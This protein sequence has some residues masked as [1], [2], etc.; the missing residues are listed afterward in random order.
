MADE[1]TE[2]A[3]GST[4]PA[5]ETKGANGPAGPAPKKAKEP[6]LPANHTLLNSGNVLVAH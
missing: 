3:T 2:G 4:E 1:V 5:P 6:K